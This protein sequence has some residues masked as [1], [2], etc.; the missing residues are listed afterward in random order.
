MAV[1]RRARQ[2][3][4]LGRVICSLGWMGAGAAN[5]VLAI[6]ALGNND[7]GL[8]SSCYQLINI[9]DFALVFP[10]A[11]SA[12]ASGVVISLATKWRLLRHWWVLVKLLLTVAVIVFSTLGVGVWVEQ[13]MATTT[14]SMPTSSPVALELV[15]GASAN[16]AA[17]RFMTWAS[18]A[19]R[20]PKTPWT[21]AVRHK[22]ATRS[23][24][25]RMASSRRWS[26]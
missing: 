2:W 8:R 6:T 9:V 21:T 20:W 16:I 12:L 1:R 5:L 26:E 19:K 17:F 4:L 25:V 24:D 14:G 7:G 3:L 10:L 22:I 11:F 15:V 13:S 18:I 23:A